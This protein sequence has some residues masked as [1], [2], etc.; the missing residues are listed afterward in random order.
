MDQ[1]FS[2]QG[3]Q[4]VFTSNVLIA[5]DVA[6][7][8]LDVKDIDIV[9]NY[10]MPMTIEDYVHRIGRTGRA[11]AKGE[12]FSLMSKDDMYL[13][14]DLFKILKETKQEIPEALYGMKT[15]SYAVK[16]TH[17]RQK[18]R[19]TDPNYTKPQG[20]HQTFDSNHSNAE[21]SAYKKPSYNQNNGS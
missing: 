5:T 8:G 1:F 15:K 7:R 13:V 2:W 14:I 19:K 6:S 18:Y 21:G 20:R 16:Q 10:D 3:D 17:H 9:I 4:K 12:A 11:G